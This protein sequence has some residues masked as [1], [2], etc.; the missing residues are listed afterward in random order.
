MSDLQV[1]FNPECSKCRTAH[2]IL[3]E[4]GVEATYV[5]YLHEP[6]SVDQLRDLLAML[7]TTD[8]RTIARTGEARWR[9]LGLD[10][11][12]DDAVLVA[13]T[14]NPILI[15]RPIAIVDGRAVVARPPERL[16]ELIDHG[17]D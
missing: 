7:G 16:L 15:E 3:A 13:M 5:D 11:A 12:D 6:P 2:S 17:S 1:W 14:E 9:E 4:R 10:E 8:P